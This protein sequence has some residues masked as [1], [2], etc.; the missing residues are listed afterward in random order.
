MKATEKFKTA[1]LEAKKAQN[2]DNDD[3]TVEVHG[4]VCV[5]AKSRQEAYDKCLVLYGKCIGMSI[6]SLLSDG[7]SQEGIEMEDDG[8]MDFFLNWEG[9]YSTIKNLKHDLKFMQS[10]DFS[11]VFITLSRIDKPFYEVSDMFQTKGGK[12]HE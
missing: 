5:Y 4:E 3:K 6:N 9:E 7:L 1:W 2:L 8:S 12:D 10:E 11:F